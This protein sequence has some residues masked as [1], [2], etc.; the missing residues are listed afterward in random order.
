[1]ADIFQEVEEDLKR[2]RVEVLWKKYGKWAIGAAVLVVAATAGFQGWESYK[3]TVQAE[4]SATFASAL[5]LTQVGKVDEATARLTSLAEDDDGY[6]TLAR[7]ERARLLVESG[8]TA[9][10]VQIWDEVAASNPPLTPLKD[11]AALLAA[12]HLV[13]SG[14]IADVKQRLASLAVANGAFRYSA[15]ELQ[16]IVA[17]REGDNSAAKTLFQQLVDEADTPNGIKSR[18]SQI[19]ESLAE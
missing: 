17:L 6:G 14:D 15:I 3:S 13:E 11:V 7:F 12:M 9:A 18:S 1:M 2:E 5:E 10:A 16:A 8:D 19:L 4:K